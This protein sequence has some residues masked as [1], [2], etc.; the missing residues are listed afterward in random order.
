LKE[1]TETGTSRQSRDLWTL[2]AVALVFRVFIAW[3]YPPLIV[4]DTASYVDLADR[5]ASLNFDGYQ[6]FRTPVFPLLLLLCGKDPALTAAAHQLLGILES[7]LLYGIFIR[8]FHSR[9]AGLLAGYCY[10]LNPSQGVMERTLLTEPVTTVLVT[11]ALYFLL[12]GLDSRDW[13]TLFLSG[14]AS[15]LAVLARPAFLFL[16]VL[17][18]VFAGVILFRQERLRMGLKRIIVL[19]APVLAT[20]GGW[21]LFNYIQTGYAGVSS[22]SGYSLISH[23]GAW[24]EKAP[25]GY[26]TIRDIY[27]RHRTANLSR[28]G[29]QENTV[30]LARKELMA[31]TGMD[32][33]HL[34][35]RLQELSIHLIIRDPIA[36]AK[37][38]S[39]SLADFWR[40]VWYTVEG[41]IRA[42]LKGRFNLSKVM[43]V[44]YLPLYMV[45]NILFLL[46]PLALPLKDKYP[47]IRQFLDGGWRMVLVYLTVWGAAVFQAVV[48][49]GDN[50][51]YSMPVE[52]LVMAVG[53]Y[54]IW[55]AAVHVSRR[56]PDRL[57]LRDAHQSN[58]Y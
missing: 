53:A 36:H 29:R 12:K 16:P 23:A 2:A 42:V 10:A 47:V 1:K 21:V 38:A 26:E 32:E 45:L 5:I 34:S 30:Y 31:A 56:G 15:G 41:G 57:D 40:P 7:V 20:V 17:Y 49:R 43:I 11:A 52:P 44:A 13:R 18:I 22:L 37:S 4:Q 25:P 14:A 33:M 55:Q 19:S 9:T 28:T 50:G 48:A 27:L 39:R 3:F 54:L 8:V 6:A 51:R 35:Q 58:Q 24:I 46:F